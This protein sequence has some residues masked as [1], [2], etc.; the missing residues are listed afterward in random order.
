LL[1]AG[2]ISSFAFI[3]LVAFIARAP[4][5]AATAVEAILIE[6]GLKR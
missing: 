1:A 4:L 2:R 5:A 6:S 3:A